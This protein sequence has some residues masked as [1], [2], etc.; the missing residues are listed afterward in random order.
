MSSV[1]ITATAGSLSHTATY[2]LTTK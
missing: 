1:T 2:T